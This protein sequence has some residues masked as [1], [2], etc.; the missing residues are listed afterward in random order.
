MD[1]FAL[2]IGALTEA[3]MAERWNS[4]LTQRLADGLEPKLAVFYDF[5][6]PV[7]TPGEAANL[8][9]AGA[10]FDLMHGRVDASET[11][12]VYLDPADSEVAVQAPSVVATVPIAGKA[13]EPHG[14]PRVAY[15]APGATIDLATVLGMA[16][17][18]SYT[19]PAS[20]NETAVLFNVPTTEGGAATVHLVPLAAPQPM[21]AFWCRWRTVEDVEVAIKLLPGSGHTWNEKTLPVLARPPS[22]G[23]LYQQERAEDR[24]L[25]W[26]LTEKGTVIERSANVLYVPDENVFGENLDGFSVY[27]RLNDTVTAGVFESATFNITIDITPENDIP[28]VRDAHLRIDEDSASAGLESG[29]EITLQLNDSEVGQVLAGQIVQLPS[30]GTLYVVNSSGYRTPIDAGVNPFDVGSP[31][32]RQYLSRVVAVSSHWG[33]NPP[34]SGYHPLGIL[35]PPDCASNLL[36][37]ECTPDQAWVGDRSIFP[38]L[39]ARVQL[40]GHTAYVRAIHAVGS[41]PGGDEGAL[42]LEMHQYYKWNASMNAGGGSWQP[43]YMVPYGAGTRQYKDDCLINLAEAEGGGLSNTCLND[44]QVAGT[45]QVLPCSK[46]R[47]GRPAMLTVSRSAIAPVKAAVWCPRKQY[48]VGDELLTGGGMFGP[49]YAY[50]HRQ[51]DFYQGTI[52]YTE[53]IEVAVAMP[54]YVFGVVI[55]M[56][57]G[58]GSVVAIRARDPSKAEGSG[59]EWVRMYAAQ[60]LLH[61]AAKQRETGGRY[62]KWAPNVCRMHFLTDTIRI[63]VDTSKETGVGDWNYIDAIEVL[64]STTIQDASLRQQDG[65]GSPGAT[66]SRNSNMVSKNIKMVYVPYANAHGDDSFQYEATDCTGDIFRVSEPGLISISIDP[67]ND[68][69]ALVVSSLSA[70]TNADEVL[71]FAV[72]VA[73]VETAVTELVIDITSLPLG[74]AGHF[75]DGSTVVSPSALP[76]RLTNVLKV[77]NFRF[78]SLAGLET[79]NVIDATDPELLRTITTMEVGFNATDSENSTLVAAVQLV[80]YSAI[81]S[82]VKA[83]HENTFEGCKACRQGLATSPGSSTCDICDEGYFR[84]TVDHDASSCVECPQFAVHCPLDATLATMEMSAGWWRASNQSGEWHWCGGVPG[85]VRF[86]LIP[87]MEGNSPGPS[88]RTDANA[89]TICRGGAFSTEE[90]SADGSCAPN[91][92]GPLCRTCNNSYFF[93]DDELKCEVCP[94]SGSVVWNIVIIV[95][96]LLLPLVS[97]YRLLDT[98]LNRPKPSSSASV[99]LRVPDKCLRFLSQRLHSINQMRRN[100]I[101]MPNIKLIIAYCQV[102][103]SIP[104]VYDVAM[105]DSYYRALSW[106]DFFTF[107]WLIEFG[108]DPKCVGGGTLG[109]QMA[110]FGFV[111]LGFMVVL[112]FLAVCFVKLAS[113]VRTL[114]LVKRHFLNASIQPSGSGAQSQWQSLVG[115]NFL[116]TLPLSLFVAFISVISVSNRIFSAFD[117]IALETDS[118]SDPKMSIR[119]VSSDLTL[120]CDTTVPEYRHV[121]DLAFTLIALWPVAIPLAFAGLLLL[122]RKKLLKRRG[123][124]L[125]RATF[126]LHKEY[127]PQYFWWEPIVLVQRLALTGWIQLV[128]A[129]KALLRIMLAVLVSFTYTLLLVI[130]KPYDAIQ[131]DILAI[132][133]QASLV[134]IF[135]GAMMLK[136]FDLTEPAGI[137]LEVTGFSSKEH[138]A[139]YVVVVTFSILACFLVATVLEVQKQMRMPVLRMVHDNHI[140]RLELGGDMVYHLFLSHAWSSAQDTAAII[141]RMLLRLLNGVKIFLECAAP[142]MSPPA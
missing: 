61:D 9:Y 57:R 32:L 129:D 64:G 98:Y 83:N 90:E 111:P 107:Q 115:R 103:Y 79:T 106:L 37:V 7:S 2:F 91:H 82:C 123:T 97:L 62:W 77:L 29:H 96:C 78:D 101:V 134:L 136:T 60:P 92:V 128:P 76:H 141:K 5:N 11:G 99:L 13:A 112:P 138:M 39:G 135:I 124:Q 114:P 67:V 73:D 51:S 95:F 127:K 133:S 16:V 24:V 23:L 70:E 10:N 17:G 8:G 22:H 105:P 74:T 58:T 52:P 54:V 14:T 4:S 38:E 15:A 44:T 43:C 40:N 108:V 102:V 27:F 131:V 1:D 49:E 47:P 137:A 87:W 66:G 100:D 140:P 6:D 28:T 139:A 125:T 126:F 45:K 121:A 118:L 86:L 72:H 94:E 109:A 69:P 42:D 50:S 56:S 84:L 68:V 46:P 35:G 117:C 71:D 120:R 93:N 122:V 75:Y 81:S 132:I 3:E 30:K 31:V 142:D 33:S 130:C 25:T 80:L 53:F 65:A 55:G 119:H 89:R 19:A 20:F 12:A 48:Y 116:R 104:A 59:E 36:S 21:D 113:A 41:D 63:E 88:D 110:V 26:P 18:E 85:S 34:Y